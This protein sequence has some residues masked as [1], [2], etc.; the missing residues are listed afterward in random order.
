[1]HRRKGS[2]YRS[3][4]VKG[5]RTAIGCVGIGAALL[6]VHLLWSW[7]TGSAPAAILPPAG[8]S[9]P[10]HAPFCFAVA[11]DSRGNMGVFED[12]LDRINADGVSFI[13]HT[14]DIV[15]RCND[16]QFDWVLHELGEEEL[17]VPFCAVPGNHDIDQH[18]RDAGKLYRHYER[19]FGPRRYWFSYGNTLFVAVDNSTER[20]GP[21]ELLWLGRTLHRLRDDYDLCFVYMHVPTR[22]PRPGGQH[23]LEAGAQGLEETI[24]KHRVSAVFASHIHGYLEDDIGGIPVFIT[25]GAGAKLIDGCGRHH[26]LLCSVDADGSFKVQKQDIGC[27]T[28]ADYPEYVFRVRFPSWVVI[29]AGAGLLAAGLVSCL[30]RPSGRCRKD[31]PS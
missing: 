12:I 15:Q 30:R 26:Y 19:A 5:R 31:T 28:N 10:G 25:G 17:G 21:E 24:R 3:G 2:E 4:E 9:L 11:G 16:R 14:G 8:E 22:D 1:M 20:Y 13:L 18:A 27:R 23:A 7:A 6:S 29:S